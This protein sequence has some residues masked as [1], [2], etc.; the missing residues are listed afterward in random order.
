MPLSPMSLAVPSIRLVEDD[1]DHRPHAA[2]EVEVALD[3]QRFSTWRR[4]SECRAF[5]AR[6]SPPGGKRVRG[7]FQEP[8]RFPDSQQLPNLLKAFTN[9]DLDGAFLERRR[10]QLEEYF[11]VVLQLAPSEALE[12]LTPREDEVVLRSPAKQAASGAAAIDALIARHERLEAADAADAATPEQQLARMS[13]AA[14]R[15]QSAWLRR[16]LRFSP[17]PGGET[18]M[19][20][21]PA[22]RATPASLAALHDAPPS[23]SPPVPSPSPWRKGCPS[24]PAGRSFV[25]LVAADPIQRAARGMA[26]RRRLAA[27]Q[28]LWHKC[29]ATHVQRIAR[30]AAARRR[31]ASLQALWHRCAATHAQR[32]VRGAVV[33]RRLASIQ[34]MWHNCAA[35]HIQRVVRGAAVRRRLAS[36]LLLWRS[37]AAT[38]VQRVLRGHQSRFPPARR[39]AAAARVQGCVRGRNMR[40]MMIA[41]WIQSAVRGYLVRR[42]LHRVLRLEGEPS[43]RRA[44]ASFGHAASIRGHRAPPPPPPISFD[45]EVSTLLRLASTPRQTRASAPAFA[46]QLDASLGRLRALVLDA[47]ADAKKGA[48]GGETSPVTIFSALATPSTAAAPRARP[49]AFA[50]EELLGAV[51]DQIKADKE[52]LNSTP[53]EKRELVAQQLSNTGALIEL[54]RHAAAAK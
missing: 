15:L 9:A 39:H 4:W 14:S 46:A 53:D 38:H 2:Y 44:V 51:V 48:M 32:V 40:R 21:T 28:A 11:A 37:C 17:S 25:Y 27:V 8:P 33:R 7:F 19:P 29:A 43:P 10:A 49:S 16:A 31:L 24:L 13:A 35:T 18:P 30:G 36:L 6:L 47:S 34:A 54:L 52:L 41:V 5:A 3:G 42:R 12:F 26:V 23:R 20:K 22:A 1:S 45:G 50:A